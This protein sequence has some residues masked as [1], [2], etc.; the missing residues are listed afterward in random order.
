MASRHRGPEATRDARILIVDDQETNVELLTSLLELEGYHDL[1]ATIDPRHAVS[2][3]A[4]FLPDLI[5]LDLMMPHLDGF[6]VMEL[7]QPMIPEGMFLPILVLTADSTLPTRRKALALGAHDFLVKPFDATEV[8]LRI[9][10]LLMIRSLHLELKGQNDVLDQRVRE[11]TRELEET[12]IEVL[13]RLALAAEYRDD[14]TG[15]HTRRVGENAA[16]LAEALGLPE[17][18]VALIRRAA[19]LHDVGKIG[20]PDVILL[21]RAS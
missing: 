3:Y 12:H 16:R 5:L 20:I 15:Q 9:R 17:G 7:L 18:R 13:E 2:L 8:A 21:S 4:E 10:N 19:P 1:K 6:Q 14:D 11:R